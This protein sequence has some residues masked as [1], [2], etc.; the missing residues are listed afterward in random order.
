MTEGMFFFCWV[1]WIYYFGADVFSSGTT[2]EQEQ[3]CDEAGILE[4]KT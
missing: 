1:I 2:E 4:G 3:D